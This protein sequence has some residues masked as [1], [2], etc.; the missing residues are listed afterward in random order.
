MTAEE[1]PFPSAARPGAFTPDELE[2]WSSLATL[3]E[4]LPVA[5]DAQLRTAADLSHFEF[6]VLFALSRAP[7]HTLRMRILAGYANSTLSRLSRAAGRMER[8]GLV[9]RRTD[10]HDGRSTLAT[11]TEAGLALVEGAT[12]GHV[13]LVR[14]IVLDALSPAERDQMR[15]IAQRITRAIS[16]HDSWSPSL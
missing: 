2:T 9:V 6:G 10:P 16:E 14:R 11:L 7:E 3:L 5:L 13:G 8:R 12:P 15:G 4:W 1:Q